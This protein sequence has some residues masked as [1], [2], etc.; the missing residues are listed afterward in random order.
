[1]ISLEAS[2]SIL[3]KYLSIDPI[4]LHIVE[5]LT[6]LKLIIVVDSKLSI[7]VLSPSFWSIEINLKFLIVV[8]MEAV[9]PAIR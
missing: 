2:K 1:M 6:I 7:V 3:E 5:N 9:T 4:P 8:D